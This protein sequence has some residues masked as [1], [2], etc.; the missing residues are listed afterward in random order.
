MDPLLSQAVAALAAVVYCSFFEWALHRFVMHT[1]LRWFSYPFRAHAIV[2]HGTFRSDHSYHLQNE[3]DKETVPMA[4]WNAPALWTLHL[5]PIWLLQRWLDR[6]ILWGALLAMVL[7]YLTYEYLHWCMHVPRK[8]RVERSGIFFRLNGHHLL[9]HRYPRKNLNV[10][11]P[12]ADLVTGTLMLR[13]AIAF[14][15]ARGPSVPDVQPRP[16]L[17]PSR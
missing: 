10:V 6:P 2:H 17:A 9:H 11:L 1:N 5:G 12:L 14:P 4:W 15:Q 7:Y 8:R 3:R 13:S 16:A